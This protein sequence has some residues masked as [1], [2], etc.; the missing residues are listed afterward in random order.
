MVWLDWSIEGKLNND[1]M[2]FVYRSVAKSLFDVIGVQK[3]AK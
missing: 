1:L 3:R 2:W